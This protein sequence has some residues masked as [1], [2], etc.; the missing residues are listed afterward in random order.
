MPNAY[1]VL[2]QKVVSTINTLET[3]YT[4]PS[5]TS[6]VISTIVVCNRG[7]SA[8]TFRVAIRPAGATIA[9]QHYIIYDSAI[10]ANDMLS[11]TCGITLGAT[12]VV[13]VYAS[14]TNLTFSAF[15]TQIT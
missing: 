14:T 3:L 8:G 2:G 15:G 9:N 4:V 6:A 12:D 10:A 13:S 11:F 7:T 5:A 1:L